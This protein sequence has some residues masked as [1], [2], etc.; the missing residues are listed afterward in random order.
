MLRPLLRD[1]RSSD[2]LSDRY[3]E[4]KALE[5]L[6]TIRHPNFAGT[7]LLSSTAELLADKLGLPGP[8]YDRPIGASSIVS[9]QEVHAFY[10]LAVYEAGLEQWEGSWLFSH[11]QV[12]IG[13][14][15]VQRARAE[16]GL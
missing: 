15:L 5:I 16:D 1:D 14:W 2:R 3:F 6:T 11:R 13:G 12:Q 9:D 10:D 7:L 8:Y 4:E